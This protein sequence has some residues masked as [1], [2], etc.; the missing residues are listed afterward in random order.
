MAVVALNRQKEPHG[1]LLCLMGQMSAPESNGKISNPQRIHRGLRHGAHA[2][3]GADS[4]RHTFATES[5]IAELQLLAKLSGFVFA[6]ACI[7]VCI[8]FCIAVCA[9]LPPSRQTWWPTS[10][11]ASRRHVLPNLEDGIKILEVGTK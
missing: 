5:K 11:R 7:C 2:A 1:K 4:Q 10:R 8:N 3:S 6:C 9:T